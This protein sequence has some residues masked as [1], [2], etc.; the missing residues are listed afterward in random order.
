MKIIFAGT[1]EFAVPPLAALLRGPHR[2]EAVYTQ[3]DRPAGRG[4]QLAESPVKQLAGR[5]SIPVFQPRTLRDSAEVERLRALA[6]DLLVVVAYALILPQS[7]LEIPRLGCVNIHA[8]LLPRWRGAAPIQ[9]AV[10]AG[11]TETGVTLM[12][13]EAG[14]DTGP[15]LAKTLC[16]IGRQDTAG[17]VHDRLSQLGADA[18]VRLLPD[19]EAGTVR[20]EVQD[21]AGATYAAKLDKSETP[22]DWTRPA[23]ILER[24]ILAFNPWPVATTSFRSALLRVWRAEALDEAAAAPPGT[25]LARDRTLDVATG[26]GVLRLLEVQLPGGKRISAQDFRNAHSCDSAILGLSL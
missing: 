23:S 9:R 10:Q 2:L 22:L 6:P 15:M 21:E 7:V 25:V 11:D 5:H 14:L 3:P 24:Q 16:P 8:S 18:L 4:R 1:P 12:F 26:A 20:P 17:D 13:M 19:L